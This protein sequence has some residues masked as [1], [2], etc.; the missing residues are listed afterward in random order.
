MKKLLNLCLALPL[1]LALAACAVTREQSIEKM[2]SYVGKTD[3]EVI[4]GWGVPDKSYTLDDG[5]EVIAY[6]EVREKYD[7]PTSTLCMGSYPGAFG[8]SVCGGG[9][10]TRQVKLICEYSFYFK[11]GRVTRWDQHGN[12]CP[13]E[14]E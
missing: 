14:K 12:N 4:K 9:G 5:T 8:Y 13:V 7:G 1:I 2:N 11:N 3:Q 6:R 10:R